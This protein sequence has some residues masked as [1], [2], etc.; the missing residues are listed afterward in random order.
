M[1]EYSDFLLLLWRMNDEMIS[2]V[3]NYLKQNYFESQLKYLQ[4]SSHYHGEYQ[5]NMDV[6]SHF[7]LE[8]SRHYK[9]D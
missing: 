7:I 5:E 6:Q 8:T 2:Q 3:I 9:Y 1:N 4:E